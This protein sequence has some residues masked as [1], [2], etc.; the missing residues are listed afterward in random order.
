M[1]PGHV[2]NGVGHGQHSQPEGKR[3]TQEPDSDF[4][5]S[6]SYHGTPATS[7][8]QPECANCF[9]K[10]LSCVNAQSPPRVDHANRF[11]TAAALFAGHHVF[12]NSGEHGQD[13]TAGPA[14]TQLAS[15]ILG[16]G[17][18][19]PNCYSAA[20]QRSQGAAGNS[21]SRRICRQLKIPA[22]SGHTIRD[23][24]SSVGRRPFGVS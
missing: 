9:C 2:P 22:E 14:T 20:A 16:K 10:V 19:L 13:G 3:H 7:E 17:S 12:N 8:G 4:R 6:G 21:L 23:A 11:V 1:A 24:S 15:P 18:A 5:K